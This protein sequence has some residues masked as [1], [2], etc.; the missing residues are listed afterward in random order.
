[1]RTYL[2]DAVLR[3][4]PGSPGTLALGLLIGD[5]SGLT[6]AERDQLRQ[7]GMS[8]I[9]AVSGWNVSI[10]VAGVGALGLALGLRGRWWA[11]GQLAALVGYVWLVG[12]EPPVV[13][14]ALMT[15]AT[16]A[17]THLGRPRHT[18]HALALATAVL[19]CVTPA[20]PATLSFQLSALA[21]LGVAIALQWTP[22]WSGWRAALLGPALVSAC[23]GLATAPLLASA[24]GTFT[25]VSI[26]SNVL[27]GPLVNFATF[28]GAAVA[29]LT[30]AGVAKPAALL[31]WLA[32]WGLLEIAA[33]FA[34][35][36]V[37][38]W[39]FAPLSSGAV[40]GIYALLALGGAQLL[41][42]GR[43]ARRRLS[44]WAMAEPLPAACASLTTL[45][46]CALALFTL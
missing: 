19:A 3:G 5:D 12:G 38:H 1:V 10:V 41:P 22:R 11:L 4:V 15:A 36:P 20:T 37:G 28:A 34:V 31:T 13:R 8:H 9:T 23:A 6:R 18:L 46:V 30:L 16:F 2:S 21:T 7:A 32:C 29:P 43:L 27:A 24:F 35:A 42:E 17:A 39:T 44:A 26:P 33:F 14:A 40:A 45:A 25:L